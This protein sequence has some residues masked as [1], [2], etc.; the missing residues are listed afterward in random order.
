MVHKFDQEGSRGT[1]MEKMDC[2]EV[3]EENDDGGKETEQG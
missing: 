2:K 3:S 1:G